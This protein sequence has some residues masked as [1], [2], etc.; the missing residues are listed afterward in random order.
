MDCLYTFVYTKITFLLQK[1]T[2]FSNIVIF[3]EIKLQKSNIKEGEIGDCRCVFFHFSSFFHI[4]ER[5]F[6]PSFAV[7]LPSIVRFAFGLMTD[8]ERL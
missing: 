4:S 3:V 1:Y 7:S 5:M 6:P 8:N 2:H